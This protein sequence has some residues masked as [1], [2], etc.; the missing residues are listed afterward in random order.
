MLT[1]V[2]LYLLFGLCRTL[3][4][5]YHHTCIYFIYIYLPTDEEF[6]PDVD[7][8]CKVSGTVAGIHCIHLLWVNFRIC[9]LK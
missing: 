8:H 1:N 3:F 9:V 5:C 4:E 7:T 6:D 2:S